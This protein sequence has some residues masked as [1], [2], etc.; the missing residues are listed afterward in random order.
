MF[1]CFQVG[2]SV[3]WFSALFFCPFSFNFLFFQ[4]VFRY[5]FVIS[6]I[7]FPYIPNPNISFISLSSLC[8][9][10]SHSLFPILITHW[11]FMLT[12]M[13][14]HAA[15]RLRSCIIISLPYTYYISFLSYALKHVQEVFFL[16]VVRKKN[17]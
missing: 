2:Y 3:F 17:I 6:V 15:V 10:A 4:I 11:L 1:S 5:S 14:V 7:F 12:F 13:H 16:A 8:F 9:I